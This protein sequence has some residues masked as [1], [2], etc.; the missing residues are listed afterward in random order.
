MAIERIAFLYEILWRGGPDG[1]QGAHA[2]DLERIVDGDEV[3]AEKLLDARPITEAEFG[4]LLGANAAQAIEAADRARAEYNEL[5]AQYHEL[6]VALA[7]T[8]TAT[9]A[10]AE[11]RPS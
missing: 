10:P 6:R 3:I 8:N 4:E 7:E 11:E 1:F 2:I 9:M 5:R